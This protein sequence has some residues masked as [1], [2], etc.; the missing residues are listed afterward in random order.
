MSTHLR[1]TKKKIFAFV[2][3]QQPELVFINAKLFEERRMKLKKQCKKERS[4]ID[5][6]MKELKNCVDEGKDVDVNLTKKLRNQAKDL[7]LSID[8][9]ESF[10]GDAQALRSIVKEI[11]NIQDDIEQKGPMDTQDDR[12]ESILRSNEI[13]SQCDECDKRV[14]W[15][16]WEP[17]LRFNDVLELMKDPQKC[18]KCKMKVTLLGTESDSRMVVAVHAEELF[19]ETLSSI[20]GIICSICA[21]RKT[22]EMPKESKN[23]VV[24]AY[25][26]Y[27]TG[28]IM[29]VKHYFPN[30]V[31]STLGQACKILKIF[32][33]QLYAVCAKMT[34]PLSIQ[35]LMKNSELNAV[36]RI[37]LKHGIG[38]DDGE[39]L[40]LF[41]LDLNVSR[42]GLSDLITLLHVCSFFAILSS[43][44]SLFVQKNEDCVEPIEIKGVILTANA[45]QKRANFNW[46]SFVNMSDE[47]EIEYQ[48]CIVHGVGLD[49]R[50]VASGNPSDTTMLR[51]CLNTG[52]YSVECRPWEC[53]IKGK[54]SQ[55]VK[56]L[57]R[58]C[59]EMKS[60]ID[61]NHGFSQNDYPVPF[62]VSTI[63]RADS[64]IP[65]GFN[66]EILRRKLHTISEHNDVL[67][68]MWQPMNHNEMSSF[69]LYRKFCKP[70]VC[71]Q[72]VMSSV[73]AMLMHSVC[74]NFLKKMHS[75]FFFFFFV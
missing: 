53:L 55:I 51:H 22:T 25:R 58:L 33:V 73:T 12:K 13:T 1:K 10:R 71:A 31:P 9:Y 5:R 27:S 17:F 54:P 39:M 44:C 69:V 70:P 32:A 50:R 18:C 20:C 41:R 75:I 11:E 38:D 48:V 30:K 7:I 3:V 14:V 62:M 40:Q 16:S 49:L 19:S 74:F 35:H 15:I 36:G 42:V 24:V 6:Q 64:R 2:F 66:F 37:V 63:F 21:G 45:M 34:H 23:C 28:E 56:L 26:H 4:D 72:N 60:W 57:E 65:E 59:V 46:M 29:F 43:D 67:F 47:L 68:S 61:D 8:N 52:N